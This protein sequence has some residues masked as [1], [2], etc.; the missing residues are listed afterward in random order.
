MLHYFS[1]FFRPAE[2]P[3]SAEVNM[4]RCQYIDED[5]DMCLCDTGNTVSSSGEKW[6]TSI[7]T[8]CP[9]AM[10]L[11]NDFTSSKL[12]IGSPENPP[13]ALRKKYFRKVLPVE[14][15]MTLLLTFSYFFLVYPPLVACC[16]N[17]CCSTKRAY[18]SS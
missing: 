3:R 12:N 14:W 13:R 18:Y 6:P 7:C 15:E 10:Q 4:G 1:R 16:R 2:P 5:G 11:H 9:H 17:H 8:N